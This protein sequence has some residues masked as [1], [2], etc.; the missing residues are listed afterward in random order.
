MLFLPPNLLSQR[1]A[2][3]DSRTFYT[4]S[5]VRWRRGGM[6]VVA[7][8]DGS[9][10]E[11]PFTG[12]E[13]AR[14]DDLARTVDLPQGTAIR[15]T[16][17]APAT[18]TVTL[19]ARFH[20]H[21]PERLGNFAWYR[22]ELFLN[23]GWYPM[24]APRDPAGRWDVNGTLPR[25]DAD[26]TI[27]APGDRWVVLEREVAPPSSEPR[28]A[29]T[30]RVAA[31]PT[32]MLIV[33]KTLHR[34]TREDLL[35]LAPDA[36]GFYARRIL[37]ASGRAVDFLGRHG[38][39]DPAAPPRM[40]HEAPLSR[41][42]VFHDAPIAL[43]SR[44]IYRLFAPLRKYEDVH[45]ARAEIAAEM[46]DRVYELEP[47]DDASWVLDAVAWHLSHEWQREQRTIKDVRTY[48][49]PFA[50]IPAVD[51]VLNRPDFPFAAEFYDNFYYTDHV[52]DDVTRFNHS[53]PNGRVAW[54]KLV[55]LVGP[56]AA[57]R[58]MEAYLRGTG[59]D[60]GFRRVAARET[61]RDLE[62]FFEQWR[63]PLPLVNYKLRR[64]A[65]RENADG[66]WTSTLSLVREGD[67]VDEPVPY[68]VGM[69]RGRFK[70]GTWDSSAGSG[71]FDVVTTKEPT[72]WTIDPGSRLRET[73]LADNRIPPGWRTLLQYAF[74]DYEFKLNRADMAAGFTFERRNDLRNEIVADIFYNQ[75]STGGD[76]GFSHSAGQF[77]YYRG[78]VHRFGAV[79]VGQHLDKSFGKNGLHVVPG[80]DPTL[81]DVHDTSSLQFFYRYDSRPDWRFPRRGAR[82]YAVLET[83]RSIRG[84]LATFHLANLEG[85]KI[86]R[87]SDN[88]V[89]AFQAK[90]GT[91]FG[92]VPADVP[93]SKLFYLGGIDDVRGISAP[94]VIGPARFVASAEWRH[95]LLHDLDWNFYVERMRMLQGSLFIDS[96]YIA[97][98]T[99]DVPPVAN[100]VTSV[101]YGLREFYDLFGVRPQILRVEV[102]QRVDNQVLQRPKL[103]IRFYVGAGQAF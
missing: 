2:A 1:L 14:G 101:G 84:R 11:L 7:L 16:L 43:V 9:G 58:A 102:A 78:L 8:T 65:A 98:R 75:Q 95:F 38:Y 39:V 20:V 81:S 88:N 94:D 67:P 49:R 73:S 56:E 48:V 5:P 54:E 68:R 24:V 17:P 69:A 83:G 103:D 19:H 37:A 85:V 12:V 89:V 96:G 66:T 42:L 10:E 55:D 74:V 64:V 26:V 87:L 29:I 27:D 76:I 50:F 36:A 86:V 62:A 51:V 60:G 40:I 59:A 92:T 32:V 52:R 57:V 53:R 34:K 44:R 80:F 91:F 93:L 33:A 99:F 35:L 90:G 61:G 41:E 70:D 97:P 30:A 72:R 15:I 6:T 22:D 23:G 25:S 21:V 100:W 3:E 71:T 28:H 77:S 79:V 18:G 47:G 82:F 13:I 31:R 45:V 46:R 63:A 4:I